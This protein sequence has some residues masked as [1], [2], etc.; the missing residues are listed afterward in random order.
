ME[1]RVEEQPSYSNSVTAICYSEMLVN[2]GHSKESG[3]G[4]DFTKRGRAPT[5]I[6]LSPT[7]ELAKQISKVCPYPLVCVSYSGA[8]EVGAMG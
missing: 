8:E 6:I 4:P 1:A 5:A 7:R 3:E 2:R